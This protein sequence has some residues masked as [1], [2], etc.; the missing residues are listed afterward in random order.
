MYRQLRGRPR[1]PLTVRQVLEAVHIHGSVTAAARELG[2][3]G[4]YI[5]ARFDELGLTLAQVLDAPSVDELL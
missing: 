5:Y 3:S 2:C 4:G 1:L